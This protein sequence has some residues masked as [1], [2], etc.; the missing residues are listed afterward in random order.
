MNEDQTVSSLVL[1][2]ESR[3]VQTA[4]QHL[5]AMATTA[6]RTEV[7]SSKLLGI[8]AGLR[9]AATTLLG[10]LAALIGAGSLATTF[11]DIAHEASL[12]R[13]QLKA[14][15]GEAAGDVYGQLKLLAREEIPQGMQE[16]TRAFINLNNVGI[17]TTSKELVLLSDL[18]SSFGS[19]MSGAADALQRAVEG[20]GRGLKQ[21]GMELA[22]VNGQMILSFR[23]QSVEVER[24]AQSMYAAVIKLAGAN[25]G[26]AS[27]LQMESLHGATLQLKD[28]WGDLFEAFA[29]QGGLELAV[30]GVQFLTRTLDGLTSYVA[31]GMLVAAIQ[32][33]GTQFTGVMSDMASSTQG[34]TEYI[35]IAAQFW[36]DDTEGALSSIIDL[37]KYLPLTGR[38]AFQIIGQGFYNLA[39]VGK[40]TMLIIWEASKATFYAMGE[41][42]GATVQFFKDV[43]SNPANFEMAFAQLQGRWAQTTIEAID[44]VASRSQDLQDTLDLIGEASAAN[45]ED[46]TEEWGAGIELF[47]RQIEAAKNLRKEYE[48]TNAAAMEAFQFGGP[49]PLKLPTTTR[50]DTSDTQNRLDKVRSELSDELDLLLAGAEERQ[51][52][53]E[54][55]Y[56]QQLL[57]EQSYHELSLANVAR[58]EEK[59]TAIVAQQGATRKALNQ[60]VMDSGFQ[61]ATNSANLVQQLAEKGS[62]TQLA[63]FATAKAIAA[64]QTI[65]MTE[66]AAISALAAPPIGLGPVAGIPYSTAIRAMGYASVAL[67]AAQAVAEVRQYAQGG[68]IPS[69]SFGIVG[70]AGPELVRGPAVVTSANASR[71]LLSGQ[72]ERGL[73]VNVHNN[74]GAEVEV[75]RRETPDA[76]FVDIVVNKTRAAVAADVQRGGTPITGALESRYGL[77]RKGD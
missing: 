22:E 24:S 30:R 18:A 13:A 32:A 55:A 20:E 28:A 8:F 25:F 54:T 70:E 41:S 74:V 5:A 2:V 60:S 35:R 3:Q 17:Q 73:V 31:S 72:G 53:L 10:P 19:S 65:V 59:Y 38:A 42:F 47:D 14:V 63:A 56:D 40:D 37:F 1:N 66:M 48:A 45:I 39:A 52:V 64:A 50:T 43:V 11:A 62:A 75:S 69:G 26:G 15:A 27:K 68:M 33:V 34:L 77:R 49:D 57:T 21:F 71:G 16:V 44:K 36:F 61:L 76:S 58:Y 9:G 23:G 46:I 29:D 51:G 67:I 4:T 6:T 7:A 12:L